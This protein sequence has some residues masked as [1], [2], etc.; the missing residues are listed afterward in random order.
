MKKFNPIH[1]AMKKFDVVLLTEAKYI[2]PKTVDWYT[3]QVLTED[4]LVLDALAARGIHAIKKDWAD[5]DFDWSSTRYILFRTTWDYYHRFQEFDTWLEKANKVTKMINPYELVRWNMDKHYLLELAE[6]GVPVVESRFI[7]QG[8]EITLNQLYK[9]TGW[10]DTVIKPAISGA[11]RHTYKLHPGNLHTHE[12]IFQRIIKHES[13]LLQPFQEKI[14]TKG[15]VSHIVING[16]HC[17]AVLKKAKEGDYRVQDDWGGTV[18]PYKANKE[19]IAFAE[20]AVRSCS[21]VP[22]YARVDLMWDNDDKLVLGEL[23]L[24]EPELWFRKNPKA[25]ELLTE[26]IKKMI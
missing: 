15:E 23:E 3:D 20:N 18:H 7:E 12:D 26:V 4:G 22:V 16:K 8:S 24:V 17:H 14:S 19:E 21:P 2:N 10:I 13:M 11:G 25:A 9:E 1:K 6:R 5:P